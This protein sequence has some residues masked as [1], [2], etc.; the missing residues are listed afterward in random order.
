MER[1]LA[2]YKSTCGTRATR[3]AKLEKQLSSARGVAT[4]YKNQLNAL[5]KEGGQS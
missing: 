4:R 1:D 2:W 3:I 5:K